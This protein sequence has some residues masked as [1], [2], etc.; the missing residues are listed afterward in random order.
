MF[1]LLIIRERIDGMGILW[2]DIKSRKIGD[3]N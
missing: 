1:Q 3:V 2:R